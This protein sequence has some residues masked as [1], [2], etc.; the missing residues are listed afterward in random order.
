[1]RIL[2]VITS[3]H[4]GGAEKLMVDLL[5]RL[6]DLGNEVELLCLDGTRTP[7]YE[8]LEATGIRIHQLGTRSNVYHPAYLFGLIR[9][10]RKHRYDIVH[11]HNTA[12]QLFAAIGGVLCSVVLVTTEH[13]TSN[14]R[15]GWTWYRPVDRSMYAAYRR[16]ICISD[17]AEKNLRSFICSPSDSRII[18]I[19]NGADVHRFANATPAPDLRPKE[20]RKVLVM[21]ARFSYQKDQDTLIRALALLPEEKF[22][23]WL[24]GEG[25][26]RG[27]LEQLCHE[28]DVAIRV[29]FLGLRMD[30]PA[31]LKAADF[32]VMSSH[33]E[34]LSLSNIE[35]MSVGKPFV[36]SDVDGLREV[37]KGA[38]VM[39]EHG[40]AA[41]LAEKI[42]QLAEDSAYSQK[43]AARCKKRALQY[44]ISVMAEAYNKVYH[45][46]I[47]EH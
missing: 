9:F 17:A 12:P 43:V 7:F 14:R 6:R 38:G 45:S 44:D 26:R 47:K 27:E 41:Q 39:F 31:V 34:G 37:T 46:V 11:T 19:Y 3:L 8:Q 32:V 10:L 13:T 23:L 33:F 25:E 15:R 20:G 28:A 36:A 4:T 40:N 2:H 18:T 24:V 42:R 35:G 30:V 1:M 16:I 21:V 22:E 29:R 5:P